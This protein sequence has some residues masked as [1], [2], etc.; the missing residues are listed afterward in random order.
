MSRR[1]NAHGVA[2]KARWANTRRIR[3]AERAL[4]TF[5]AHGGSAE[6]LG[7]DPRTLL[8]DLLTDLRH[9]ARNRTDWHEADRQARL[10]FNAEL[11][12]ETP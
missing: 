6:D 2:G 9:W 5:A 4:K 1:F 3:H 7:S 11:T 10:H 12:E 8:I